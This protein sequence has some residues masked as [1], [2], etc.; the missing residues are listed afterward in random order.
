MF[1]GFFYCKSLFIPKNLEFQE[2][3]YIFTVLITFFNDK[4]V[5]C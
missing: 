4:A 3:F 1:V 2:C 5:N